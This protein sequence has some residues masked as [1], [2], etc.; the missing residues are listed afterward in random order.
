MVLLFGTVP[1]HGNW[2]L[3]RPQQFGAVGRVK[4]DRDVLSEIYI[5]SHVRDGLLLSLSVPH[6]RPWGKEYA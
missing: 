5:I 3:P 2:G 6:G 1:F 4:L